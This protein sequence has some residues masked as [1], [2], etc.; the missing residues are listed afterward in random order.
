[1]KAILTIITLL[2]SSSTFAGWWFFSSNKIKDDEQI[3]FFPS[4][5]YQTAGSNDWRIDFHGW[6]FEPET[7]GEINSLVREALNIPADDDDEHDSLLQ[8][9]LHWF[10]VDNERGKRLSI[11]LGKQTVKLNPSAANGHFNGETTL[12]DATLQTLSA[13]NTH[14]LIRFKALTH[15]NDKRL[16]AGEIHPVSLTGLSIISDLDD[17]I[18][19]SN[20]TNK[21]ELIKN[22]FMRPFQAVPGMAELYQQWQ[23]SHAAIFHY[24]SASPWQLYPELST[25]MQA[26][27]FPQGLFYMKSFRLK[28]SSFFN[29]FSDPVEYKKDII[30]SIFTR[31]PQREFILVGDSGEKDPEVYGM[32]ARQYPGRIKRI[33]IRKVGDNN[34]LERFTSAFKE[35]PPGLWQTFDDAMEIGKTATA[36]DSVPASAH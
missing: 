2:L 13:S 9:R 11:E 33:L 6:I 24:V 35:I 29:L 5:A 31:Y 14:R 19:I 8:Q 4:E 32:M 10:V 28:D 26:S 7:L 30:E 15:A 18:K 3:I 20:V 34:S 16:F 1:M 12:T 23:Q 25:F 22:T 27:R 36:L 21:Q 17:T